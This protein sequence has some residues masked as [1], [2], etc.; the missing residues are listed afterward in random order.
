MNNGDMPAMAVK[1][2]ASVRA[3][4]QAEGVGVDLDDRQ[5][6]GLTKREHFAG[7]TMQALINIDANFE[8]SPNVKAELAVKMADAL[9][10]ELSNV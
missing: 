4:R 6:T 1:V 8:G 7:L 3:R 5:Y 2:V 10:E 9:L